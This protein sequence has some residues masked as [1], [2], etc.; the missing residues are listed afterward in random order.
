MKELLLVGIAW[1]ASLTVAVASC[2]YAIDGS[3]CTP[4][5]QQSV[6]NGC[7]QEYGTPLFSKY[8]DARDSVNCGG[9]GCSLQDVNLVINFRT[10][11]LHPAT[12]FHAMLNPNLDRQWC[13]NL[14][15]Q[16]SEKDGGLC[17]TAVTSGTCGN[18]GGG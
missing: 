5:I 18:C 15:Q 11:Q 9:T 13:E 8:C 1:M 17:T 6:A 12:D 16:F 2:Y 3:F 4:S 7:Y 10:G 14:G